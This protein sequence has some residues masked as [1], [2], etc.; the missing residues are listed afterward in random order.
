[1]AR[2]LVMEV[3]IVWGNRQGFKMQVWLWRREIVIVI[4]NGTGVVMEGD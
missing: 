4:V 3:V 1:M 2:R